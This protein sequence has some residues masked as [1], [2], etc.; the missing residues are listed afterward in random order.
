VHFRGAA[1]ER[2]EMTAKSSG[3]LELGANIGRS[4]YRDNDKSA[5]ASGFTF[6]VKGNRITFSHQCASKSEEAFSYSVNGTQLAL[7]SGE[8]VRYF[9]W[10]G[11]AP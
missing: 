6:S 1:N 10:Q 9:E 7:A 5:V 8:W 3:A 11:A 2:A 4:V